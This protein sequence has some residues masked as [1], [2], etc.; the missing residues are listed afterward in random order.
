[1]RKSKKAYVRWSIVYTAVF[2]VILIIIFFSGV[3][4]LQH[5]MKRE[6]IQSHS[7]AAELVNSKIERFFNSTETLAG[8]I[9]KNRDLAKLMQSKVYDSA[10][11]SKLMALNNQLSNVSNGDYVSDYAIFIS[12]GQHLIHASSLFPAESFFE[13]YCPSEISEYASWVKLIDEKHIFDMYRD[14][15]GDI[16]Y[17]KSIHTSTSSTSPKIGTLV[18]KIPK[19]TIDREFAA[20]IAQSAANVSLAQG[21]KV[22]YNLYNSGL[23]SEYTQSE[24]SDSENGIME[25]SD[26]V[27]ALNVIYTVQESKAFRRLVVYEYGIMIVAILMLVIGAVVIFSLS[28]WQYRPIDSLLKRF[29]GMTA[30]S[31]ASEFDYINASIDNY[32]KQQSANNEILSR[33]KEMALAHMLSRNI[34]GNGCE[35]ISEIFEK[36][37]YNNL[38]EYHKVL[39]IYIERINDELWSGNSHDKK[40]MYYAIENVCTELFDEEFSLIT[41][42]VD[43]L[44]YVGVVSADKEENFSD[45]LQEIYN[46]VEDV[47]RELGAEIRI[48]IGET[49]ADMELLQKEYTEVVSKIDKPDKKHSADLVRIW[50]EVSDTSDVRN[51]AKRVNE[52]IAYISENYGDSTM[53]MENI[54][55]HVGLNSRYMLKIFKDQTGVL[56]KDYILKVRIERAKELL[57]TDMT[58]EAVAKRCGYTSAH[59]FIR[60]FKRI[61]GVTPGEMR[62]SDDED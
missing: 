2:A 14:K 7:A 62:M 57:K 36:C 38:K 51:A 33:Y 34:T 8:S 45:R 13:E 27:G 58:I 37:G 41:L 52:I 49:F 35:N 55:Q 10:F 60:A 39:I 9:V 30:K 47:L 3:K 25:F 40:L 4:F 31:Y 17:L 6:L 22:I 16:L 19:M 26:R 59:S 5:E 54:A 15:N 43:D 12:D 48:H 50:E 53:T 56:L 46:K 32:E 28:K 21:G 11:Y 18:L 1:M 29:G 24:P 61:C 20:S 42:P 44:F 23:A